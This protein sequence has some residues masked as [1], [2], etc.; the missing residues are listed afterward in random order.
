MKILKLAKAKEKKI[1]KLQAVVRGYLQRR[2][3]KMALD[4]VDPQ[5]ENSH[6]GREKCAGGLVF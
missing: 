3:N 1:I 6:R 4:F 5:A 2:I